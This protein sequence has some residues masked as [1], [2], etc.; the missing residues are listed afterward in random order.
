LLRFFWEVGVGNLPEL[1]VV[2]KDSHTIDVTEVRDSIDFV[3][4]TEQYLLAVDYCLIPPG[5]KTV[6]VVRGNGESH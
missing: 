1:N 3:E 4:V 5:V 6:K 2:R